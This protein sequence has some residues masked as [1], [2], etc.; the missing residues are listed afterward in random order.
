LGPD[1]RV[2]FVEG[3]IPGERVLVQPVQTRD[4]WSSARVLEVLDASPAR[5]SPPCGRVAEGCGG[6][7]WQHIDPAFQTEL[8]AAIV[9]DAL[10]RIGR[11]PDVPVVGGPRLPAQRYRTTVRAG[12]VDGR[13]SLRRAGSHQAV[14]L[15]GCLVAHPMVAEVLEESRFP[16]VD[17]VTIRAGAATGERLVL[18][19]PTAAGVRVADDVVVVGM[20]ELRAGRQAWHHEVV[21]GHR[22]RISARS[23][24]QAS[25][26]GAAA[27]AQ[28]VREVLAPGE[29]PLLDL[30][31][32][33]G[34]FAALVGAAR[35]GVTAVEWSA[36]S[37]ADARANLG[38]AARV[39]RARVERWRPEPAGVVV[40]DP[41]RR[42]LGRAGAEVVAGAGAERVALVSCDPAALARDARLL[43]DLGYRLERVTVLDLFGHT[44]HVEA[45]SA[46]RRE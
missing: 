5:V 22:F 42:G 29:G 36:S 26:Q 10:R 35:P 21:G 11:L 38:R 32:G 18:A 3:A 31:A 19:D 16:G 40:A 39:V 17:E 23:F 45:V 7:D 13:A 44:S 12:V 28:V 33:V 24:F 6:C 27:L 30:Y 43:T 9:G 8:R 46:F 20:D 1:G 37:V 2:V 4:R 15:D 34:L 25:P 14:L 41:A